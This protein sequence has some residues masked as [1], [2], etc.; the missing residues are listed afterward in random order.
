MRARGTL[1][2]PRRFSPPSAASIPE[3]SLAVLPFENMSREPDNAFFTDGVQDQILTPLAKMAD[4]KVICRTVMQYK[5]APGI[6][7]RSASSS[8]WHTCWKEASSAPAT[9]CA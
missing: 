7:P 1:R 6:Y 5:S 3:K 9:Q 4:L 8:A 2:S